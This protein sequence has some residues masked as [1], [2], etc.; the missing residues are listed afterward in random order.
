[1]QEQPNREAYRYTP[2]EWNDAGFFHNKNKQKVHNVTHEKQIIL[3]YKDGQNQKSRALNLSA[4]A[5]N[6]NGI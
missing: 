1:M 2:T 6:V 4:N 5:C 3:S